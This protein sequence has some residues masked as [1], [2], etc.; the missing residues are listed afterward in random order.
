MEIQYVIIAAKLGYDRKR[1]YEFV[2]SQFHANRCRT[3]TLTILQYKICKKVHI[4]IKMLSWAQ[5]ILMLQHL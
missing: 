1:H 2:Y 5:R 3:R 4:S